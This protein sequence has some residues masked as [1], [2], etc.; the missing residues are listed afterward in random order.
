[1]IPH[2]EQVQWSGRGEGGGVTVE[3]NDSFFPRKT[4]QAET[5]PYFC[6]I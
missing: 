5:G 3:R 6:F 4:P 2:T 1:M